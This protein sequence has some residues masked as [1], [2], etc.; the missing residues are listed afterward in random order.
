M[1]YIVIV[2]DGMDDRP[3][4]ALGGRT[5]LQAAHTA[6]M[7][8][9]AQNGMTGLIQTIPNGMHPSSDVGNM[10]LLG[11]DPKA[12]HTG[13]APLEAA[14]LGIHLKEDEI[15]FRCNLIT[16]EGEKMV[17]YSAGHI[18]TKEASVLIDSLNTEIKLEGVKFYSGKSYRHLLLLKC[19]DPEIYNKIPTT[20]PHDILG[21]TI[22]PYLPKGPE[23]ELLL[24]LMERSKEIFLNHPVNQV[25]IDL[26][27][28]PANMIWLWGQGTRPHLP[29]FKEK[30]GVDGAIISA[31][32]LVNGIGKLAGLEIIHVPGA[33]GYIDTDYL[34]KARH[35][36]K[37]LK[38]KDFVYIHIEA[39]DEA[40]HNGDLQ[41]KISSIERIDKEIVGTILDHFERHDDYRLLVLPDHPTPVEL[42]THTADP[43]GF[44]M[45]G[46]GVHPDG[47]DKFHEAASKEKGLKFKSGE[48]L[49]E[50]FI[51]KNAE[52]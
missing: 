44:V 4:E 24:T 38:N 35:A 40:G 18:P 39:P 34:G 32:D 16:I 5:P 46:K 36:L 6:N 37:A 47:S 51:K 21:K 12:C 20:A 26:K 8:F 22:K 43:V 31:V 19:P 3:V 45:Y 15:A 17:D 14:S 42:R 48:A 49:M 28:N 29:S 9:L 52:P 33:T 23:A 7:D 25:R 13:R 41:A 2:P 50:Y 11:Y 30:F 1:K 10:S 27:E